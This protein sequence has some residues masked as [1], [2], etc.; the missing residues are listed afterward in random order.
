[1]KYEQCFIALLDEQLIG[2]ISYS[3]VE[4]ASF[5]IS[6][7][8]VRN[9]VGPVKATLFYW[10]VVASNLVLKPNQIYL[11]SLAV[12]P[13][14]QRQGIGTQLIKFILNQQKVDEYVLEVLSEKSLGA[15]SFNHS[16]ST[17]VTVFIYSLT[18]TI[19]S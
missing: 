8:Q 16:G 10:Q 18:V 7:K 14:L 5:E 11:N 6:F 1:M 12:N 3:T 2:V 17:D 15:T 4:Q 9:I 13:L 19:T